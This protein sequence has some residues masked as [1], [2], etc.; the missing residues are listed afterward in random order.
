MT[1]RPANPAVESDATWASRIAQQL[2]AGDVER[3]ARAA[4][5]GPGA[6]QALR[7]QAGA[8]VLRDTC[9]QLLTRLPAEGSAFIAGLLAG[10]GEA[11]E[12]ARQRYHLDIVWTGPET[13]PGTGRLTA[14]TIIDLIGQARQE[15]LI[16]TYAANNDPSI[17]TALSQAAERGVD[18]TILAERHEDNPAYTSTGIP[19]PG[20]LALRL[21]W[22]ASHRPPGAA[23]HAKIIVV[24]DSTALVGSANFT[25]RAM[26][27]NLECGILIRGGPQPRAI[28]DHIT[29]LNAAGVLL[30]L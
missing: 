15:I 8:A 20:L 6:V 10:A 23:L 18:I 9:D 30:R 21:R 28:R 29:G 3:L 16:V 4:T 26:D 5:S 22:P 24:D 17:E 27:T 25:G 13:R 14:A 19:F 11:V 7:G 1:P 2:P 12:Q